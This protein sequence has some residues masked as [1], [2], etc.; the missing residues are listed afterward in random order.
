MTTLEI[1]AQSPIAAA[2]NWKPDL[3]PV[4]NEIDCIDT[5]SKMMGVEHA[6]MEHKTRKR[7]VV[8]ARQTT[9][10]LICKYTRLSLV[11]IGEMFGGRD[12]TTVIHAR[13]TVCDL[14]ES[15]PIY[16]N[17]FK[18]IEDCLLKKG[19]PKVF[20]KRFIPEEHEPRVKPVI[21][22]SDKYSNKSPYGIA[23]GHI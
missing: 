21:R 18:D 22:L 3:L 10:Y 8:V 7:E 14:L 11:T 6:E 23:T 1:F 5:V 16:Y 4:I 9:M 13:S 19:T 20:K 15:D 2:W 12:H 17:Q